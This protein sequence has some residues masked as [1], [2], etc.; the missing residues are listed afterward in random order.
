MCPCFSRFLKT[1]M[2]CSKIS[3]PRN[4]W[5][6]ILDQWA[7][8]VGG[9]TKYDGNR[10]HASNETFRCMLHLWLIN[11]GHVSFLWI[12]FL[13]SGVSVTFWI[14][15]VTV[16]KTCINHP[17]N[18]QL[19]METIEF[20]EENSEQTTLRVMLTFKTRRLKSAHWASWLINE[21]CVNQSA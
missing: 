9:P 7:F 12:I 6:R 4:I 17:A 5:S 3:Q 20:K 1:K 19:L 15:L 21:C 8:T 18:K 10:N 2:L 14:N 11:V 16:F 13:G